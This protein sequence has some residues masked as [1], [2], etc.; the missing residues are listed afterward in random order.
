[1]QKREQNKTKCQKVSFVFHGNAM[2][3]CLFIKLGNLINLA[4]NQLHLHVGIFFCRSSFRHNG[5]DSHLTQN[6][7]N[8]SV[9]W[10]EF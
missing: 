2:Q 5:T 3:M 7:G 6:E 4:L 1:M 10:K 9:K 8:A